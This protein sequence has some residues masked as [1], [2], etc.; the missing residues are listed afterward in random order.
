ML[1]LEKMSSLTEL[2]RVAK[3]PL[4]SRILWHPCLQDQLMNHWWHLFQTRIIHQL[5]HVLYHDAQQAY[6]V[7]WMVVLGHVNHATG[8]LDA[9]QG[10]SACY[11]AVLPVHSALE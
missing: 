2:H 1:Y 10:Q 6:L 4:A 3:Y 8:A 7:F 11:M 5:S 9:Q